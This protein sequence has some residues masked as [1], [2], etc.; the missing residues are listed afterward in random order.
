MGSKGECDCIYRVLLGYS[1]CA[2]I[3]E[4]YVPPGLCHGENYS[5]LNNKITTHPS[6][7]KKTLLKAVGVE[8]G[9]M[10]V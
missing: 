2:M 9:W 1:V 7:L 6:G 8:G 3:L 5:P 4:N 10:V